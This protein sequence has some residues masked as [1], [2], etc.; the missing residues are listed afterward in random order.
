MKFLA[1][2]VICL[3]AKKPLPIFKLKV[4]GTA[5]SGK[6]KWLRTVVVQGRHYLATQLKDEKIISANIKLTAYTGTATFLMGH[7]S[8]TIISLF[9]T[10]TKD[11]AFKKEL[12]GAAGLALENDFEWTLLDIVDESSFVG[13]KKF[14]HME[15]RQRQG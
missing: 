2:A 3:R 8:R 7:G 4:K 1:D 14:G 10:G 6:T 15:V 9:R 12:D 5:G 11:S 13:R